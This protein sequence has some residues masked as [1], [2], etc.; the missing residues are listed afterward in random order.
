MHKSPKFSG[1]ELASSLQIEPSAG[2]EVQRQV[3]I[4]DV[5]FCGLFSA[6]T[7]LSDKERQVYTPAEGN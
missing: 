6:I 5:I 1:N 3:R 2:P 4:E 7:H